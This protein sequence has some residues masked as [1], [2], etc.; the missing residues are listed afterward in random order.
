LDNLSHHRE[1]EMNCANGS[2][3]IITGCR[4]TNAWR[5]YHQYH[6]N[7]LMLTLL[8][9]FLC[10]SLIVYVSCV[11]NFPFDESPPSANVL[12]SFVHIQWVRVCL[13]I[14]PLLVVIVMASL[15]ESFSM[16]Q[17]STEETHA[18]AHNAELFCCLFAYAYRMLC[19]F[20]PF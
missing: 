2:L 13:R 4:H 9:F 8:S 11:S 16:T 6:Y 18:H 1:R 12:S 17:R 14:M 20:L 7:R 3:I 19:I 10:L 15:I 5:K